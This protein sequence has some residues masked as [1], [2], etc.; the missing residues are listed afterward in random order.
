MPCCTSAFAK[1]R[2]RIDGVRRAGAGNRK[3]RKR[4]NH[5]LSCA[6]GGTSCRF[7]IG[8]SRDASGDCVM[9]SAGV[10]TPVAHDCATFA[11]RHR[12]CRC[13]LR[14]AQTRCRS[15]ERLSAA[16]RVRIFSPVIRKKSLFF[17]AA[18]MRL[19][20]CDARPAIGL[21]RRAMRSPTHTPALHI[22]QWCAARTCNGGDFNAD[23]RR[24]NERRGDREDT[25]ATQAA[26]PDAGR[27]AIARPACRGGASDAG[28]RAGAIRC[29]ASRGG[30]AAG[31]GSGRGG[32]PPRCGSSAWLP[33]PS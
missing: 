33:V 3:S 22:C 13:T 9:A 11:T 20:G 12:R 31:A 19:D 32:A 26:R 28:R 1:A 7:V 6:N 16:Q 25:G 4:A 15:R 29:R 14:A 27:I 24:T 10:A 18:A 5:G 8:R 23:A 21:C 2:P 17:A 30:S